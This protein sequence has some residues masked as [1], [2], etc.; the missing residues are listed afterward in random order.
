VTEQRVHPAILEK[1]K[2]FEYKHL[3]LYLQVVSGP[4]HELAHALVDDI[5]LEGSQAT[6]ALQ[7]LID[8]KDCAVRAAISL[9]DSDV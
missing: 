8:A 3:P 9:T 2:W 7:H 6:L 1:L 5:G 4:F